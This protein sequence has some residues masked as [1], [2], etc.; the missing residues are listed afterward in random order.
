MPAAPRAAARPPVIVAVDGR[1][2]AGKTTLAVELATALREHRSVTL[3]HLED[4][5]PGWDG[6]AAGI[7]ACADRV[8]AP[9]R[10]GVAARWHAWDWAAD[11]EGQERVTEPADIVIVEGV[12]AGAQAA[13]GHVDAVVWV[14]VPEAE[15]RQR[16]LARDGDTYAPHWDRW[17][18]QEAAWLADDDVPSAATV[19]VTDGDPDTRTRRTVDAL[20]SL[21]ALR[22]ALAPERA[23]RDAVPL[24]ARRLPARPDA[25]A[26]FAALYGGSARAVWLDSSDADTPVAGPRSRFSVMADDGGALG[27]AVVHRGGTTEVSG[28]GVTARFAEPFFRWL[29]ADWGRP[30]PGPE[31]LDCGFALG[32]IGYLGYELKRECGGSDVAAGVP[33]AQLVG[34]GRGVVIDHEAGDVWLLALEAPDAAAWLDAAARAVEETSRSERETPGSTAGVS[35]A[36]GPSA[37][38][39]T[40]GHAAADYLAAVRAAQAEIAEGNTYEVCLTTTLEARVPAGSPA[41]DAWSVYRALRRRSPAPFA[42]FARFGPLAVAS[43]SPE[44]FLSISAD[45]ALRAEPIKGTRRRAPAAELAT[46]EGRRRD[47]EVRAE[48]AANPKDRAENLMIVDLLR[49][50][51][52]HFAVPGSVAVSRLFAVE[53]YTTVHQLVSTIDDKLR[54]GASRAEAV[55]AA[56]PPGSMT[57]APK[58]S[59]MDILDRLERGPRGVY[60]GA[61]GYFSRTGAADTSVV[62]RTLVVEQ[63]DDGGARL[64]LG[65][66]GAVV[67]DSD[68]ADEYEEIRTKAFAVLS[69]LG[70]EFPA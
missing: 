44:R 2:G 5:Y 20:A 38:A 37:P 29:G 25:P 6:L 8:L 65:V 51:L 21:P 46:E 66:G 10:R 14:E 11:A 49:N 34:A 13:R 55:A 23:L 56:F 33:D 40:A 12:G 15:R 54:P 57:G 24:V 30:Q 69:T 1:S 3:F 7:A 39:F 63:A 26:L 31:G 32:W 45:G 52:S 61:I 68:P 53:S 17:A 70:A 16:A 36:T 18:A 50:D 22:E 60:S 59:T 47:D 19:T 64:A 9:L 62:I 67:A 43:T 42:A 35:R 27:R 4:L 58:V 41:A 28:G 48:L